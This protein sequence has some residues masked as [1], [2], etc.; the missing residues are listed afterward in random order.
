MNQRSLALHLGVPI[1]VLVALLITVLA[2]SPASFVDTAIGVAANALYVLA[3]YAG[4]LFL[5]SAVKPRAVTAHA[6][7]SGLSAAL[8]SVVSIGHFAPDASGLPYHWVL[9]WPFCLVGLV[10]FAGAAALIQR[11][12]N[13]A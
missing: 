3:P 2:R 8:L 9:Y 4:F 12:R 7:M 10:T 11:I 5:V 6:G 13:G 1:G